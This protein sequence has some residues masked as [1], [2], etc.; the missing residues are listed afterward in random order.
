M[1]LMNEEQK[2]GALVHL[3]ERAEANYWTWL[4]RWANIKRKQASSP[5]HS[6]RENISF[7][8]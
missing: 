7:T 6:V 8:S 2:T 4:L 3:K 1:K 5:F